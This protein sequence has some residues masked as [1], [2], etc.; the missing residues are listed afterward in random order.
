MIASH[1]TT[2]A[3]EV[4]EWSYLRTAY[5]QARSAER[6]YDA[7]NIDPKV[8]RLEDIPHDVS[9]ESERLADVRDAAEDA[10]MAY[11]APD[12][13]G[14]ALKYMIA[15]GAGRY[16]DCWNGLLEADA[17]RLIEKEANTSFEA[18]HAEF[19]RLRAIELAFTETSSLAMADAFDAA[20]EATQA[21]FDAMLAIP[22]A[23]AR[24]VGAK[25]AAMVEF[26]DLPAIGIDRDLFA[27]VTAEIDTILLGKDA[28]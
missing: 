8:D 16:T 5:E 4:R 27:V 24:H 6:A 3:P 23:S 12:A 25:L 17:R 1:Q 22:V 10:L 26:Y 7:E 28:A 18:A 15:H 2:P 19:L 9:E 14:F 13:A 20:I 11:P 21:A